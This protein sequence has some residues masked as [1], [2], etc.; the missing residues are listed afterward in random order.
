[1]SNIKVSIVIVHSLFTAPLKSLNPQ[2]LVKPLLLA[3]F[4]ES[5]WWSTWFFRFE[6]HS[7]LSRRRKRHQRYRLPMWVQ[8]RT[9]RCRFV[10]PQT[11]PHVPFHLSQ[12]CLSSFLAIV[13]YDNSQHQHNKEHRQNFPNTQF[14]QPIF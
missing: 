9:C 2:F 11:V 8:L 1:M 4:P 7:S 5:W 3:S 13:S 12:A 6:A 10:D 14:V